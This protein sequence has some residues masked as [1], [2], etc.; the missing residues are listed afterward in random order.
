[1]EEDGGLSLWLWPVAQPWP[2]LKIKVTL[3]LY[4]A[5][6][7][8]MVQDSSHLLFPV[9]KLVTITIPILPG[10]PEGFIGGRTMVNNW[11]KLQ[12]FRL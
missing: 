7:M 5:K 10:L 8:S 2:G 3:S 9:V 6:D 4:A 12:V 1:M 11:K